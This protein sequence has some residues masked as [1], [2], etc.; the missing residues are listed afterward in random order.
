[1]ILFIFRLF[2]LIGLNYLIFLGSNSVDTY[3]FI[4][5]IKILFNIDTSVQVTY[6]IV[7][8]FVSILTLLLIRVFKP[9][10]EVYL[11][12]YSRY[13]FYILISLISLSSVYIICRVYGYSRLYLIIYVFISST[14]LLFSGKMIKN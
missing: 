12:F 11:L 13:F 3:Q 10:I 8:I 9:F 14:F 1:M 4:E 5:D 2:A 6:W 7:S